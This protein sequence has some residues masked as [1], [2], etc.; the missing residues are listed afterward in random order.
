MLRNWAV[1]GQSSSNIE[2]P[3]RFA[4]FFPSFCIE[5]RILSGREQFDHAEKEKDDTIHRRP[6][7]AGVLLAQE[8]LG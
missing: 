1:T 5:L 4:P 2:I 8:T 7:A 6:S 3:R